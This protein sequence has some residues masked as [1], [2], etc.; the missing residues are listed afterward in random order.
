MRHVI[1]Q[2]S[3]TGT[4]K[5]ALLIKES[6]LNQRALHE[7]YVSPL[8]QQGVSP[9]QIIAFSLAY[10]NN[11]A[12]ASL[13]KSYL[14][15]LLK[16]LDCLG[17]QMLFV[18][19]SAYFKTLT[20]QRKAEPH[21]GYALPCAV[22]GYEHLQVVLTANYQG[23]FYNPELQTKIDLSVQAL[24]SLMSGTYT[25]LGQNI[26][27]SAAYPKTIEEIKEQL[28]RLH[29][30][31]M[32]ACDIETYSLNFWESGI[33]TI[34]FAWDQ[35]NGIAFGVNT[36]R[37]SSSV[38]WIRDLAVEH[39]LQEFFETYQGTLIWHN[40]NFDMK[41]IIN[42]LWM[43]SL[44][45]E[46]GKQRGIEIMTRRFHDTKLI[47]YLATNSTAGNKL[48]LKE[49][50]HEFAG[51]YAQ[52]SIDDITQIP[53]S[54][55]LEY[56]LVDCLSTWYVFTK[57]YPTMLADQQESVYQD[58]F[59]P[60]VAVILQMELT[61]MPLNMEKVKE[62]RKELEHEIAKCNQYFTSSPMIQQLE[63]TLTERAWVSDYESRKAKA[64]NPDKIQPKD[65][66]TFPKVAFNPNSVPQLQVLLY[67]QLQLPVLDLTDSKQPATGAKTL[68]KLQNHTDN[69]A[70]IELLQTLM[71][72]FEADKILGTFITAMEK[73]VQKE[74]GWHYLHGNFN[75]G[76][77]VSGRLSSSGP[78]LQNLPSTGSRY[79]KLIK[80]CFQAPPGWLFCG[81]DF[82][83]LE[84]RIS[85]LTTKD[86]NKLRVYTEGYDGHCLRAYYYFGDQMPDI[87]ET[88]E[89]INSIKDKYPDLRQD[90]KAPTFLLTYGGTYHG[91][92]K[93]L[94]WPEEKAKR[95]EAAYHEM[96]AESDEWV[97]GK[98]QQA[99]KDGYVTVAFGLRLRTPLLKQ[100]ILGH[101][102]TPYEASAEAR[103]AGN[104]LG[105]SYG[106]LN[107]RA[108]IDLQERTFNSP[109]RLLIRPIAHIHDAQYFMVKD[110][111]SVMKWLNDNLV[112]CM[113]WQELEEIKHPEVKLGGELSVFYP[114][115]AQEI[116][117]PNGATEDEILN[118]CQGAESAKAA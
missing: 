95:I 105:Q 111:L 43:R 36:N 68:K 47:T 115:W 12:P 57:H 62:A 117:L 118:I 90:S 61:G 2:P 73:A 1:F 33:A 25:E 27:H 16:S 102:N 6:A 89:S 13:Q 81:A 63:Y 50:A 19:D 26:I 108:A 58:I 67:E 91:M 22:S 11:K 37:L 8:Q 55:L 45:D 54:D 3:Q 107:N 10:Q 106:L 48:S 74:D 93:N 42:S 98:L 82:A 75:L 76:G 83:S 96:Y 113:Q 7:H 51:N 60:S 65:R 15:T 14:G 84:D 31:P 116:T 104:A 78:N 20:K 72:F 44:L 69:Q 101:S 35:H 94:G 28:Q 32:L 79:A 64:N 92:M 66:A 86:T 24:A 114:S 39:L 9:D 71:R 97:Q 103:T 109:H 59:L 21:Y 38:S 30:H 80:S 5:T 99:S 41:V 77:T 29:Q 49:Q 112:E 88:A 70:H 46:E 110:D 17:V 56:N 85:A 34:A 4:Y 53:L 18:A 52:D 40:A 23:L 100:V 87:K